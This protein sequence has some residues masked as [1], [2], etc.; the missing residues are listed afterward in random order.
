MYL[1][2]VCTGVGIYLGVELGVRPVHIY[3]MHLHLPV[4]SAMAKCIRCELGI[5]HVHLYTGVLHLYTYTYLY[6]Y[7]V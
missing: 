2:I 3:K 6:V 1:Q 5:Y 4:T 7:Q